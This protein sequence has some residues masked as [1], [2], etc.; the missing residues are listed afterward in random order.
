MGVA[1]P[2]VRVQFVD[3][4]SGE[5][6]ALGSVEHYVPGTFTAKATYQDEGLTIPNVNPIA[7]T[8]AGLPPFPIW[9]D[10]LYRQILK[11]QDGSTV[12]DVVTGFLDTGGG[13]GGG[14]VNGPGVS[15]PGNF[16][17]WANGAGTLVGD[18]GTP[19][20]LAFATVAPIAN[21]G[22]G[23]TT[24]ANAR[25][26]LGL[27]IGTDVQAYNLKLANFAALAGG[28]DKLAYFTG[29]STLAQTD[30]TAFA[31]SIL[32]D[33]DGPAVLITI[34]AE[35]VGRM[36]GMNTYTT[37]TVLG[38]SDAGPL[39]RMNVAT[40]NTLTIPP[41]SSVAWGANTRIDGLQ[42]GA[43]QT[44]IT[45]GA[46]VTIRSVGGKTKTTAQYSGFSL[47]RLAAD[48]WWLTGDITT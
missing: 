47:Y 44:T 21:G 19:G 13:G 6:V 30:F 41:Q 23:A 40:P 18:G 43:G 4:I 14:D 8:G 1:V 29:A 45:P 27:A 36:T 34:G 26:A 32:D 37:N 7:L 10:G 48:E 20:A 9:G 42:Y 35:P 15:V 16:A 12:H 39:V 5:P 22:T 2:L 33:A 31:R 11:R 3:T 24:A 17:I 38:L 28:A 46:G 25:T